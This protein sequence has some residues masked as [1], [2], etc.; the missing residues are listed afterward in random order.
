[1]KNSARP[2]AYI[3]RSSRSRNDPGDL[4][5]EFQVAKVHELARQDAAR[6]DVRDQDW[7]RSAATDKTARR[8]AFMSILEEVERGEV[9]ALYAYS[10]DR[11][12][13]SVEW[14]ARLLNACRRAG[15][16]IVTSEGRFDPDNAMTD[17]LFYFQAMQNE[18]YS[19]QATQKRRATVE[20][21]RARG[22][23]LGIAPYGSLPGED[24]A[25]II[26]AY[27][28]AG[29]C[30]GAARILNDAG[31]RTRRGALW[32]SKVV[33]DVL[34]REG[35]AYRRR[36]RPG[37]KA[38][39]DWIT[40]RLLTCHCGNTMTAMDRRSP[41]VTCYKARHDPEHPKPFGISE[42]KLLP[43]LQAEAARFRPPEAVEMPASDQEA[44]A[45]LATK[46]EGIGDAYAAGAYGKVGSAEA[47][48]RLGDR[49]AEL[50]DAETRLDA[51][52]VITSIPAAVD[53]WW[54]PRAINAVLRAL[55]S[56]VQLGP[57][58]LPQRFTWTV[59][60]WRA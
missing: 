36:P 45:A 17:Q 28:E 59:P 54:P 31:A 22:A 4:S 44:R 43:A 34:E 41:R 58:L 42:A 39:A 46:R 3:R 48:A 55:W 38:E 47:K 33:G 37:V 7:G 32:S 29:S 12:A 8:L 25:P 27:R 15:V 6:L 10:T 35:V 57:D 1:M 21:Q 9:S 26:A 2:V 60:E 50:E 23:R 13:R 40:Y 5:R 52:R 19:R 30:Y 16:P 20:R 49:L 18:G 14:A 51:E 11:I 56:E 24:L 53:W